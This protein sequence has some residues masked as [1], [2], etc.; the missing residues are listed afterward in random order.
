MLGLWGSYLVCAILFFVDPDRSHLFNDKDYPPKTI[1]EDQQAKAD[2]DELPSGPPTETQP[3]VI[4]GDLQHQGSGDGSDFHLNVDDEAKGGEDDKNSVANFRKQDPLYKN[5]PVM[6][7]LWLYFVLK[8]AL[9]LLL[10]SSSTVTRFYFGWQSSR[11]GLFLAIL[12]L[13]MFPANIVVA[14]L[15]Q[16]YEDRE[17]MLGSLAVMVV[18]AIGILDFT[19]AT[20]YPVIQ[21][22]IFSVGLFISTNSLEGPNMGLLTKSI[23]KSWAIGIFN[24]GFLATEAG[25]LARSVGD[26][27]ISSIAGSIGVEN[28][29]NGLFMPMAIVSALSLL[30]FRQLFSDMIEPDDEDDT[31]SYAS[32]DSGTNKATGSFSDYD[33]PYP[34]P[35]HVDE[36]EYVGEQEKVGTSHLV[37][38]KG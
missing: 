2:T 35:Q 13:L 31:A 5:K 24:S 6:M 20:N 8:L 36:N 7:T 30:V 26:V 11:C 33:A 14:R 15:S 28:L 29:L 17:L 4:H 3:L 10:S 21:Y 32:T 38:L 23:P 9:E 34:P 16:R 25:T 19:G 27:L 37:P 12:G 1:S 18:S 22:I